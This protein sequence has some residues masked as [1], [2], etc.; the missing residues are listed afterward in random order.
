MSGGSRKR[1]M[2][3]GTNK[4]EKNLALEAAKISIKK[5]EDKSGLTWK[6]RYEPTKGNKYR[7]IEN[8]FKIG[9]E[10]KVGKDSAPQYR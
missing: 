8:S 5:H 3:P 2:V 9:I 10:G 1:K 4:L 6:P 7:L